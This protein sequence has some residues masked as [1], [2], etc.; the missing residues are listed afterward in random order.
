M[1]RPNKHALAHAVDSWHLCQK[2]YQFF[3]RLYVFLFFFFFSF[4]TTFTSIARAEQWARL[5]SKVILSTTGKTIPRYDISA[6]I[7]PFHFHRDPSAATLPSPSF[8]YPLS[9]VPERELCRVARMRFELFPSAYRFSVCRETLHSSL[10][11]VVVVVSSS[12]PLFDSLLPR[13]GRR[14][15]RRLAALSKKYQFVE[16]LR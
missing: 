2:Q 4:T 14:R 11:T 12:V 13:F 5:L 3:L 10:L 15:R 9:A 8:H 7:H 1:V 6:T 16:L